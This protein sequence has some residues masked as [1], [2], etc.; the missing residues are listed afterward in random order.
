MNSKALVCS[1][2]I[3]VGMLGVSATIPGCSTSQPG[4]KNVAGTITANVGAAPDKVTEAA[5]DTLEEL[6]LNN[7]QASSTKVDGKVTARTAQDTAV[8]ISVASAGDNVSAVEIR[9]GTLGD[10]AMSMQ[11]LEGI[12]NRVK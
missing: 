8:N 6:K 7:I 5:K 2:A 3:A 12:Q 11:I 1:L 10:K 9:V 4:A